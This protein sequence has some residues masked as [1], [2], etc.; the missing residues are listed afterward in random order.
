LKELILY[1]KEKKVPYAEFQE[2]LDEIYEFR[3]GV[4]AEE[5]PGLVIPVSVFDN[6]ALS[7]L[8]TVV[9]YLHEN[10]DLRFSEISGLLKRD[11]R[12]IGVTYRFARKKMRMV[13]KARVSAYSLPVSVIADRK[14]SVLEG[15]VYY[16]RAAYGLSYH[17]VAVILRRDDRTVWTVYQ[18]ALKKKS[19]TSPR[20]V[21]G[22]KKGNQYPG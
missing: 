3:L 20:E 7:A 15:I 11:Q 14:L 4:K 21:V 10:N 16:L 1:F 22:S 5:K 19:T 6:D 13:L 12:A 18:R 9:K 2:F 8:E 17:D